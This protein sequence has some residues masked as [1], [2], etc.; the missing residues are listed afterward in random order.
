MS[1][2][3]IH[4]KFSGFSFSEIL[5]NTELKEQY[6]LKLCSLTLDYFNSSDMKQQYH[7]SLMLRETRCIRYKHV[8]MQFSYHVDVCNTLKLTLEHRRVYIKH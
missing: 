7:S 8:A 2:I 4:T 3:T 1:L 6:K 5:K